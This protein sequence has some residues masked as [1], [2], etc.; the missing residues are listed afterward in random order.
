[1]KKYIY[2]NVNTQN[3]NAVFLFFT[4]E[5]MILFLQILDFTTESTVRLQNFTAHYVVAHWLGTPALDHILNR[6]TS[7]FPISLKY[8][9]ALSFQAVS[10]LKVLV[11]K[12]G[13]SHK[14]CMPCPDWYN[15][16]YDRREPIKAMKLILQASLALTSC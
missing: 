13:I 6:F 7:S 4:T 1:M 3:S 8:I 5:N 16:C 10:S 2:L 11:P 15:H 14:L 9:W 12:F